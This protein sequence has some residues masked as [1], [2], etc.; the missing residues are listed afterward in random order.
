VTPA[1][2]SD[3]AAKPPSTTKTSRC[4]GS[5][6]RTGFIMCRT[7]SLLVLCRRPPF[8]AGQHSPVRKGKAHTRRLQGT[9]TKSL[10]DTHF[11]PKQRMTCFLGERTA[12]R[13]HPLALILRPVRRSTV[14][15]APSSI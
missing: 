5:Q 1:R 14:S 11:K 2:A 6:R 3:T 8:C 4:P 7:Q 15:S 12:S 13:S 10:I 9:E